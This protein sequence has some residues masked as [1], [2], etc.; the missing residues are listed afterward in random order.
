MAFTALPSHTIIERTLSALFANGFNVLEVENGE[1]AKRKV[2]E[3][4]P[5][6]AEVQNNT[7]A[8]LEEIGVAAEVLESGRFNSVRK[9]LLAM[10]R[11]TQGREMRKLG[12]APDWDLGSVHAVTQDGQLVIVSNTGSQLGALAY[13]GGRVILVVGA[14]KI[15]K[16]LDEA[17]QRV[18]EYILPLESKRL[19]QR[20]GKTVQSS[21]SKILVIGREIVPG[22]ITVILVNKVLGF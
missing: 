4:L 22:R 21:V 6:G 20:L 18:D 3:L 14:Q 1:E 5:P 11:A 15:V 8:T 2:L 12:A 16:D 19:S 9:Q 17:R 7:S 13:A 10:D